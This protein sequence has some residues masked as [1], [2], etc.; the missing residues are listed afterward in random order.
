MQQP[1]LSCGILL[2]EI[3][4]SAFFVGELF[5]RKFRQDPP[6]QGHHWVALARTGEGQFGVA[7]YVHFEPFEGLMLAGGACT[8]GRVIRAMPAAARAALMA[9]GGVYLHTLRC[10]FRKYAADCEAF[11]GYCGDPRSEEVSLQA[12]FHKAGHPYLLAHF[13][14]ATDARRQAA[15]CA[16]VAEIGPF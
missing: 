15:L 9:A 7:C 4:D 14:H 12:G 16:R 10:G 8:D 11:F 6:P 1:L 5:Q 3:E 2:T 13:P